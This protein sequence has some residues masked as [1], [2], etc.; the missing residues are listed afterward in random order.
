MTETCAYFVS[1][2][3]VGVTYRMVGRYADEATAL[4]AYRSQTWFVS[5]LPD[6]DR[7]SLDK[8]TYANGV[9]IGREII[10]SYGK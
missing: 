3:K 9:P 10:E 4:A 2:E 7:V 6:F 8:V 5:F 1:I